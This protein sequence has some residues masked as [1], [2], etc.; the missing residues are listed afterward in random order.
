MLYIRRDQ[1]RPPDM[2]E[3]PRCKGLQPWLWYEPPPREDVGAAYRG[4]RWT[5]P[6]VDPCIS[7]KRDP[8]Y[9][10]KRALD[11]RMTGADFPYIPFN[12]HDKAIL[13]QRADEADELFMSRVRQHNRGS[14][15]QMLGVMRININAVRRLMRRVEGQ[16]VFIYG[17]CGTGKTML[18]CAIARPMLAADV[19]WRRFYLDKRGHVE[20]E[21]PAADWDRSR[22]TALMRRKPRGA[23]YR[24]ADVLK[25]MQQNKFRSRRTPVEDAAQFKGTLFLDELGISDNPST[26]ER[27]IVD[28]IIGERGDRR[29]TIACSNRTPDELG[30]LYGERVRSR[31][32][33]T[34]RVHI[35]GPDW[36]GI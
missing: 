5:A 27:D 11:G 3:C 26:L 4:G 33:A 17:P 1:S 18:M 13:E 19:T 22:R 15:L 7:C 16:S 2:L 28:H 21:A 6:P 9:E 31:L 23:L 14:D 20:E 36:R 34:L 12:L 10:R 32:R 35:D 24:R 30:D 29:C 8:N 25:V